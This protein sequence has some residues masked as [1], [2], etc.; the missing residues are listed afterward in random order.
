MRLAKIKKTYLVA[1]TA[2]AVGAMICLPRFASA[3]VTGQCSNCHTMHNS[4]NNQPM[5]YKDVF[6]TI[7]NPGGETTPNNTL[8]R[9]NCI[10]CH[11]GTNTGAAVTTPG[12][13]PFVYTLSGTAPTGA[14][15]AG[16]NFWW[17]GNSSS[18]LYKEGHNVDMLGV[19][20]GTL[21]SPPGYTDGSWATRVAA[22][23]DGKGLRSGAHLTCA[24]TAG[25]H[26]DRSAPDNFSAVRG[27]H[28]ASTTSTFR[29][30]TTVGKSF[31]FLLGVKGIE[32]PK[33]EFNLTTTGG[34]NH[35]V[36]YGLDQPFSGPVTI[37]TLSGSPPSNSTIIT[38]SQLCAECHGAFHNSGVTYTNAQTPSVSVTGGIQGSSTWGSPWIRHPTDF[39]MANAVGDSG[40]YGPAM[41]APYNPNVPVG[42]STVTNATT[43]VA[44]I[45][46]DGTTGGVAIVI[47]LSC[48]RAHGSSHADL[49][50]WKYS[51][52]VASGGGTG[53]CFT[54]HTTKN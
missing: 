18:S 24:G 16:G 13:I 31:R 49:L 10:Q 21:T 4:Q 25:C 12:T 41:K 40:D 38:I 20:V 39:N 19:G 5:T 52:M 7:A 47:C 32:D 35:N 33:W 37:P 54:C 11:T 48:H 46:S 51:D 14:T 29:D 3:A 23:N 30:G 8:L 22:A 27:A 34:T 6:T 42:R 1:A 44:T 43:A 26:G 45:S 50:R 15:L 2:L 28:H 17:T 9:G 53:G 36:Y